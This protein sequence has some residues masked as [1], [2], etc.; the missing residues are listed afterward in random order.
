MATLIHKQIEIITNSG[1]KMLIEQYSE[2]PNFVKFWRYGIKID[3]NKVNIVNDFL[4]TR[5]NKRKLIEK[6]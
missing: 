1:E 6:Y 4:L 3:E 2:S 5:P